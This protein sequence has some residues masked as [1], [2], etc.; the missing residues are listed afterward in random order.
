MLATFI[1]AGGILF[2]DSAPVARNQQRMKTVL[3]R[4]F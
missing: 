2:N 3:A 1:P 4:V